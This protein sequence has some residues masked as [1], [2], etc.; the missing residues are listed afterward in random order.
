MF[1]YELS[2]LRNRNDCHDAA[3]PLKRTGRHRCVRPLPGVLVRSFR[4]PAALSRLHAEAHEVYRRTLDTGHAGASGHAPLSAVR[5]DAAAGARLAGK[6]AVYLL[7]M[8]DRRRS[9]HQLSRV[10][11]RKEF[12]P[13]AFARADQGVAPERSVCELLQLRGLHQPG[14]QLRLSLLPL[15]HLHAR[16][17]AAAAHAGAAQTSC[18]AEADGSGAPYETR[19]RKVTTGNLLGRS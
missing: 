6:H 13:S 1:A 12:H 7:A 9:L 10:L 4:E 19:F 15:A 2:R 11:E 14:I 16:Y 8:R 18:R 17:E 3:R 5:N